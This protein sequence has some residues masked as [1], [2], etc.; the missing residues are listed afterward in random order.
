M[1][2]FPALVASVRSTRG[3]TPA[4]RSR[5]IFSNA[6]LNAGILV[7]LALRPRWAVG[8]EHHGGFRCVQV[9]ATVLCIAGRKIRMRR[10]IRK[11]KWPVLKAGEA[12]VLAVAVT[13]GGEDILH[14][15]PL[16]VGICFGLLHALSSV[17]E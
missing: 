7:V 8:L 17:L 16:T 13:V 2:V 10:K 4:W 3:G 11:G 5:M 15:K 14:L 9:D 1:M 6:A 12:V